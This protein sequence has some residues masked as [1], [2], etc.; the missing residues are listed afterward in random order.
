M[1]TT[2]KGDDEMKRLTKPTVA[3]VT[4]VAMLVLL[5]APSAAES[6]VVTGGT[7]TVG[8]GGTGN[9]IVVPFV[10]PCSSSTL[11]IT[12]DATT[13]ETNGSIQ[14]SM[15]QGAFDYGTPNSH[16]LVFSAAGTYTNTPAGTT[17]P[18]TT[19]Q[20]YTISGSISTNAT[21]LT[22]RIYGRT[23]DCTATTLE[24][25]PIVTTVTFTGTLR[26]TI[27]AN[28]NVVGTA[29]ITGSGTLSAFGCAAPFTALNGRVA[30]I[31]SMTVVF[32]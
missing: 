10:G 31:N 30:T 21:T 22:A 15:P 24:C 19:P 20:D 28:G 16:V 5:A 9:T 29:T 13:P 11:T 6:G 1:T 25:G 27:D 14:M 32:T 17:P 8:M 3:L 7:I 2:S 4:A 26:G 23:G 12:P 18:P